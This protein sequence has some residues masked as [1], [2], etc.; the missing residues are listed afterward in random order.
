M[1]VIFTHVSINNLSNFDKTSNIFDLFIDETFFSSAILSLNA[2]SNINKVF[3]VCPEADSLIVKTHLNSAFSAGENSINKFEIFPISQDSEFAFSKTHSNYNPVR[4]TVSD[5]FGFWNDKLL[6]SFCDNNA[7]EN[8][9]IANLESTWFLKS[10]SWEELMKATSKNN[11]FISVDK[12]E[13][14]VI[15]LNTKRSKLIKSKIQNSRKKQWL[16]I[17]NNIENF[18][19]A[20]FENTALRDKYFREFISNMNSSKDFIDVDLISKDFLPDLNLKLRSN[21]RFFSLR[22][23]SG[24]NTALNIGTLTES[25]NILS[26]ANEIIKIKSLIPRIIKIILSRQNH[27]DIK[28]FSSIVKAWKDVPFWVFKPEN[29]F[30]DR[31]LL[32]SLI[33]EIL[34]ETGGRIYIESS[35]LK[36]KSRELEQFYNSGVCSWI[37][38]LDDYLKENGTE[39]TKTSLEKLIPSLI[40]VRNKSNHNYLM[41]KLTKSTNNIP[42]IESLINTWNF[43]LDGIV[44][45]P[46]PENPF[47]SQP[48]DEYCSKAA[49]EIVLHS[50]GLFSLCVGF[51]KGTINPLNHD[52]IKLIH[53]AGN[54]DNCRDCIEKFSYPKKP[55]LYY[56]IT[57]YQNFIFDK[58]KNKTGKLIAENIKNSSYE[59]A[60]DLI[61]DIL[62]SD[63]TNPVMWKN[64]ELIETKLKSE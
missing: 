7:I 55:D 19:A 41:L 12:E 15:G 42:L 20:N 39:K 2:C 5:L 44:I 13:D 38:D 6:E 62:K 43:I 58:I 28:T 26:V 60:L 23:P 64:I 21:P 14:I 10:S 47:R 50:N 25:K 57:S 1:N 4:M 9:L 3:L 45:M 32:E 17:K 40:K 18:H 52:W 48:K 16:I 59:K 35:S 22:S 61:E 63:A 24:K 54:L 30:S 56:N 27:P 11:F 29:N 34:T 36:L 51:K 49:S 37:L 53:S 31:E 33:K 8:C 46:D